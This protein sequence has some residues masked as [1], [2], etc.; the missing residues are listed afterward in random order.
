MRQL[1][2]QILDEND[3]L[4]KLFTVESIQ[5]LNCI[6]QTGRIKYNKYPTIINIR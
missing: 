5:T 4:S 1:N 3:C 2:D 6:K